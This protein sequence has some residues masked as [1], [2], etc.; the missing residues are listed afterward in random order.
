MLLGTVA[1]TAIYVLVNVAFVHAL[2]FEGTKKSTAPAQIIE[3]AFGNWAGEEAGA[4]AAIAFASLVAISALGA[5]HGNIFTG[6]R[7][8]Y[9][10]GTDHKLYS[11][12]G[13]WSGKRGTPVISLLLQGA[14]TLA[15]VMWFGPT[16][17]TAEGMEASGFGKMVIFT[18]PA[19]WFFLMLVGLSVA[20]LRWRDPDLPRPYRTYWYPLPPIV[21]SLFS[22]FMVYSSVKW[23]IKNESWE[24]YWSMAILAVGV[25]LSFVELPGKR[26]PQSPGE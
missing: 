11:W 19:F 2:G 7:I 15:L 4:W 14:I 25:G 18:T 5:V 10:M 8:Y 6:S 23:A 24:V 13:Q 21:L 9:A 17:R 22:M 26:G 1:V 20:E 12:L 3:L 16:E